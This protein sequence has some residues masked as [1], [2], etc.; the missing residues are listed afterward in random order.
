MRPA[1]SG[2]TTRNSQMMTPVKARAAPG[3]RKAQ[4]QPQ[5][6]QAAATAEPRMLP[7]RL[8]GR[9]GLSARLH[10]PQEGSHAHRLLQQEWGASQ[11]SQCPHPATYLKPFRALHLGTQSFQTVRMLQV[12][13]VGS[14]MIAPLLPLP[15]QLA[16]TATTHGQPVACMKPAHT[17]RLSKV[18]TASAQPRAYIQ[19]R[20]IR[21]IG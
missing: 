10:Q 7:V 3:I 5:D 8:Q 11:V 14:P 18:D 2:S 19:G 9:Q 4:P 6:R 20:I 15:Y 13:P 12:I 16:I 17:P 21:G 1:S